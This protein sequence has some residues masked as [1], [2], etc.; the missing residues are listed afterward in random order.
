[1]KAETLRRW[2]PLTALVLLG[3]C[4]WF[5]WVPFVG[6]SDDE[7]KVSTKPAELE[8]IDDE[9]R[10]KPVWSTRVGDGFGRKYLALVPVVL[11]DQIFAADGYGIVESYDRFSGKRVWRTRV[12]KPDGS[13]FNPLD[14]RDPSFVSGGLGA[15]AGNVYLGTTQGELI[16]LDAA[17][18]E[19]QWRTVVGSEVLTRP[20]YGEG[21]VFAQT[22]DGRLLALD[23]ES[24]E[25]VWRF[26][27]QVPILT[28]RG[29][30]PPI[31]DQGLVYAGFASGKIS[32]VRAENG[33]PIWEHRVMLPE[34]RSELDRMVDIDG[35]PLVL[36]P[37]LIAATYQGRIQALRRNDG[38]PLWE[39]E[40]SSYLDL[41]EGLGQVYVINEDDQIIALDL[42]SAEDSWTQEGLFRRKLSNPLAFDSYLLAGDDEGFL[43]VLAQSDGRFIGRRRI[44]SKGLRA[45]PIVA[46]ELIYVLGN[47]GRLV[48]FNLEAL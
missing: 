18:G 40:V 33:E 8:R 27:N 16:A 28:L 22:I 10:I 45:K 21:R 6:G 38:Q 31:Y 12:G 17:S 32:A 26:D 15:G 43:H 30:A 37:V 23:A 36:G 35:Q 48:A 42:Q 29:T 13:G 3:G 46:D 47:G 24:G 19:E 39:R 11:A 2:L 1:M 20:A 4:S 25:E 5:S 34:G 14:R 44:D 41:S 7:E 9:V